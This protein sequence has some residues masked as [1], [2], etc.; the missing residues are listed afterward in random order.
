VRGSAQ[1][2]PADPDGARPRILVHFRHKFA[3]FSLLNDEQLPVF[4]L[5]ESFRDKSVIHCPGPTKDLEHKIWQLFGRTVSFFVGRGN[6]SPQ[7]RRLEQTLQATP[8]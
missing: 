2:P 7:K 8:V 1:A 6:P 5:T 4:P 3:P